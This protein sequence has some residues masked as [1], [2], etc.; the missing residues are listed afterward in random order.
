MTLINF[1]IV[2]AIAI[3]FTIV[4]HGH[5]HHHYFWP[6]S[7]SH[8]IPYVN[9][10]VGPQPW[11]TTRNF[12]PSSPIVRVRVARAIT[13]SGREIIQPTGQS[14]VGLVTGSGIPSPFYRIIRKV[15]QNLMDQDSPIYKLSGRN[16]RQTTMAEHGQM[17]P[18]DFGGPDR[19]D[20][21]QSKSMKLFNALCDG[22]MNE[23]QIQQIQQKLDRIA[24]NYQLMKNCLNN[25]QAYKDHVNCVMSATGMADPI[26][27]KTVAEAKG[28]C[29]QTVRNFNEKV[30]KL[31]HQC[32]P[33]EELI[34]A[35]KEC[36]SEIGLDKLPEP[37]KR[38][39]ISRDF[40]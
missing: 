29:G 21:E 1:S 22:T 34:N 37:E 28:K 35:F 15:R 24:K 7:W 39:W 25:N 26:P 6:H 32:R 30:K 3:T 9:V 16:I 38:M 14:G 23:Q 36:R 4:A 27:P 8:A 10:A 19:L 40:E 18:L 5:H 17:E 13:F 20:K 11:I 12:F 33:N 31:A 2:F